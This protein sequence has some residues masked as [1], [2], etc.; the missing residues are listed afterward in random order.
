MTKQ[1]AMTAGALCR[2]PGTG[3]LELYQTFL[4]F[5]ILAIPVPARRGY[6]KVTPSLT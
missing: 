1:G 2:S 4:F 3:T 6:L 5:V